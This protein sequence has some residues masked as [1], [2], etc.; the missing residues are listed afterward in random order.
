MSYKMKYQ[1]LKVIFQ[2]NNESSNK[3]NELESE[4]KSLMKYQEPQQNKDEEKAEVNLRKEINDLIAKVKKD[5][6]SS[7][8]SQVVIWIQEID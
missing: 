8:F 1:D 2:E 7:N 3:I 5:K 4:I 6:A